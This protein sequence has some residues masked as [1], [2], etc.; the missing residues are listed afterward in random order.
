MRGVLE[1]IGIMNFLGF[2]VFAAK[3]SRV[4]VVSLREDAVDIHSRF[5]QV[6]LFPGTVR[7]HGEGGQRNRV[8]CWVLYILSEKGMTASKVIQKH[9]CTAR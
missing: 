1:I 4:Y 6:N 9:P 8:P 3:I 2:I 5:A 7:G